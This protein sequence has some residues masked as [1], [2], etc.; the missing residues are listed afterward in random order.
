MYC[1]A[2]FAKSDGNCC[3]R[4]GI[5]PF[6]NRVHCILLKGKLRRKFLNCLLRSKLVPAMIALLMVAAVS[7]SFAASGTSP[8]HAYPATV[9]STTPTNLDCNGFGAGGPVPARL[10][11]NCADFTMDENG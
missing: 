1:G 5:Y 2:S 8:A 3:L 4:P 6:L 7:I 11:P 9:T 10:H